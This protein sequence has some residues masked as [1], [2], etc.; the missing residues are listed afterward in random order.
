MIKANNTVTILPLSFDACLLGLVRKTH[1]YAHHLHTD[2]R[3]TLTQKHPK[4]HTPYDA[5][6]T[7][8]RV[9]NPTRKLVLFT[10]VRSHHPHLHHPSCDTFN[11]STNMYKEKD[12]LPPIEIRRKA[13]CSLDV[14]TKL[15]KKKNVC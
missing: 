1:T 9:E 2:T 13:I 10:P 8:R 7:L 12:V 15:L 4:A 11:H 14:S 5:Q 3:H 6:S